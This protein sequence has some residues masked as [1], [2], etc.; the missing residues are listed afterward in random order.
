MNKRSSL[1]LSSYGIA[2][3]LALVA[4]SSAG[5]INRTHVREAVAFIDEAAAATAAERMTARHAAD[6]E[7]MR[8]FRPGYA[9]WKDVFTIP[10]GSI[11]FGSAADGRRLALI[12]ATRDNRRDSIA[13]DLEAEYGAVI[14][15]ETR[16]SFAAP[17]LREYGSLLG[18]WGAIYERFGVPR[19]IGL[20]Q[21][22]LES[23]FIGARKSEANAVGLCQWLKTN[24]KQLDRI[25]GA[26]IEIE[27]QTTQAAYCA[28]YLAVLATKYGSFIPALS[29]HHA[30]G[31]TIGRLLV[32]GERLGGKD[33]R[34]Q[35]FMASDLAMGLRLISEGG[36]RDIYGS[37]GPR[38]YRYAEMVFGNASTI[39]D[40]IAGA[41]QTAIYAMR[42]PREITRD[43]IVSRTGLPADVVA[44]YNPA[45]RKSVPAGA[46]LYLP[47]YEA[48]FGADAAYWHRPA[49][50][51]FT[52]LLDEFTALQLPAG[53]WGS[54]RVGATLKAFAGRF[55][56]TNTEEG[57][58]MATIL[59]Y[60]R[61]EA[62]GPRARI[63]ATYRSSEQVLE[64]FEQGLRATGYATE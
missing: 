1:R 42:T 3:A 61:G 18:E 60:V 15:N 25:D 64:L 39:L 30:G 23:G 6:I 7:A 55:L 33:A 50:D 9:F 34:E 12:R 40:T 51:A 49:P 57:R 24:W 14:H 47:V 46:T 59:T 13:R 8:R 43:E 41:A 19:E 5:V 21:A 32:N 26:V 63:L 62:A 58:V 27:N 31:T 36:Y 16:G 54:P 56:A 52:R 22:L 45:L 38:S 44:R 37:Y 4:A 48:A 20:A 53:E 2:L 29:E 10:D 17:G 28:A 11:V 35:Y